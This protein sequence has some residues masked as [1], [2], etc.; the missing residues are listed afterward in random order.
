MF[1]YRPLTT[2]SSTEIIRE[3]SIPTATA[4]VHQLENPYMILVGVSAKH[5]KPVLPGGKLDLDDLVSPLLARCASV[6]ILREL[7][8]EIGVPFSSLRLLGVSADRER[9]VRRIRIETLQGAFSQQAVADLDAQ[10]IVLGRYGVPDFLFVATIDS[11]IP[12]DTAEL[13][14]FMWIDCR[15]VTAETLS[16]GHGRFVMRYADEL[17]RA[18]PPCALKLE[19]TA[20]QT[21]P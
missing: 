18:E 2:G 6:C 20:K 21:S 7:G 1:D 9:D 13:R 17:A 3:V 10:Q 12:L 14:N 16:A 4:I 15:Y 8:E 19:N 11:K 5:P